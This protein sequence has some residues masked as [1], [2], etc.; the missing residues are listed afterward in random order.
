[1][2]KHDFDRLKF[3]LRAGHIQLL[4]TKTQSSFLFQK[5]LQYYKIAKKHLNKK[6]KTV[7]NRYDFE[8]LEII[9]FLNL[10]KCI[11]VY[12][13]KKNPKKFQKMVFY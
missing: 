2:K 1:M 9:T 12:R 13:K 10:G 5:L 7:P 11:I 8:V 6:I 4:I 3:D